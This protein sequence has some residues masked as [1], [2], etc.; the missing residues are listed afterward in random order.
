M[1]IFERLGRLAAMMSVILVTVGGS[2]AALGDPGILVLLLIIGIPVVA[3]LAV[4]M[5]VAEALW[6]GMMGM[7]GR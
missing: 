7:V 1:D 6:R 5:V 2:I 4:T 3:V